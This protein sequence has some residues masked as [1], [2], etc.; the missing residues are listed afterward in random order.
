MSFKNLGCSLELGTS[1]K[2]RYF[3]SFPV[4]FFSHQTGKSLNLD[5]VTWMSPFRAGAALSD[6]KAQEL[7]GKFVSISNPPIDHA[8]SIAVRDFNFLS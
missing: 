6:D 5:S 7:I 4:S 8:D 1:S 2:S 3:L